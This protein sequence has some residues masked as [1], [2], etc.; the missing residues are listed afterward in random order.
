MR[1][2]KKPKGLF[3]MKDVGF[4]QHEY[5]ARDIVFGGWESSTM[6]VKNQGLSW[7]LF[8]LPKTG[9]NLNQQIPIDF[10]KTYRPTVVKLNNIASPESSYCDDDSFTN[11][12]LMTCPFDVQPNFQAATLPNF[13][14]AKYK[15]K[16][17]HSKASGRR[18]K[19]SS[20]PLRQ[21]PRPKKLQNET[22]KSKVNS[23]KASMK[24]LNSKGSKKSTPGKEKNEESTEKSP[25]AVNE[26]GVHSCDL[27]LIKVPEKPKIAIKKYKGSDPSHFPFR[28]SVSVLNDFYQKQK[29]NGVDWHK[30]TAEK[31]RKSMVALRRSVNNSGVN[32]NLRSAASIL[33]AA[34]K[35]RSNIENDPDSLSVKGSV[36]VSNSPLA[37]E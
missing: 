37:D 3:S 2:I 9:V 23:A 7:T 12:V 30:K 29:E 18:P 32:K 33:N 17:S 24:S 26:H 5:D 13:N 15:D 36:L 11:T 35:S 4:E 34:R 25:L 31:S 10:A 20:E 21:T 19:T 1:K 8:S 28:M 27:N 6:R 22:K 14:S 16:H